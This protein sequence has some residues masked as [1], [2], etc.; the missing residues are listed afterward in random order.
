MF[1]LKDKEEKTIPGA[2]TTE[3]WR[4]AV[5]QEL[6]G[7]D[8]EFVLGRRRIVVRDGKEVTAEH[9]KPSQGSVPVD[10]AGFYTETG[11]LDLIAR[12][13][14]S[15]FDMLV[16]QLRS[17]MG[18]V[19]F[20]GAGF[21]APFGFPQW[22]KFITNAAEFHSSPEQVL[23]LVA[24]GDYIE[25]ASL[26]WKESP[27]RFQMRVANE[28]G[29]DV[30]PQ[31]TISAAVGLLPALGGGPVITTNFDHVLE[32]AFRAAGSPFDN[33]ITGPQ[34][35]SLIGAM[36][37]NEHVLIKMHGDASDRS[38][39]VFT[40]K[41]Y[42][43][44]YSK[45]SESGDARSHDRPATISQL[46][47]ILFTNR[48]LLFLGCSLDRDRTLDVLRDIKKDLPGLNH[49][50]ILA[51]AFGISQHRKRR[52]ELDA[53][54]VNPLWFYPGDFYRIIFLLRELIQ[55]ASTRMVWKPTRSSGSPPLPGA[56][57]PGAPRLETAPSFVTTEPPEV[58]DELVT[59]LKRVARRI[60]T[61]R[62]AFFLG[63]GV[64]LT[65]LM[66]ARGFYDSLASDY[67]LDQA[68]RAD[69][70]QYMVDLEGRADAWATARQRLNTTGLEPSVVFRF[71]VQLPKFFRHVE[72]LEFAQQWLF[73]T[74]YDTMLEDVFDANDEPFHL[75]YYQADG[76]D[77]GRFLHRS[78]DGV[79]RAIER[80]QNVRLLE[81]A[82]V[83]VKLDGGM[84]AYDHLS[85][86]VAISPMDFAMS[87]G[88]LP[89]ALPAV[90]LDILRSR[91]L[92]VLGSSL[93][94]VHVQRLVR[95][96]TEG[97]CT[98]KT[99]AIQNRVTQ[100][101]KRYWTAARVCLQACDLEDFI[102][103]LWW[104]ISGQLRQ[105]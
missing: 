19:P 88:R 34:P 75:L 68:Y 78:P 67:G 79:V 58:P 17:P 47:W 31:Q 38:A 25:A 23:D 35:D 98:T 29:M 94:A 97:T 90:V 72:K 28:F 10:I 9:E 71:L 1:A 15:T 24:K 51:G 73:T 105:A 12:E 21:S 54:G 46:A 64:H 65:E 84:A 11:L 82:H 87:A 85:E 69:I 50:A 101:A 59:T 53:Y 74:N 96:S 60:T 100:D 27:D 32:T 42:G 92:L 44:Q 56:D 83:I 102:P 8:V 99:W 57:L 36:H 103:A 45:G 52:L 13:N 55:E 4:Y 7:D 63:A 93:E 40:G 33:I 26:L 81:G 70:A 37:R 20:V 22:S 43:L 89:T 77:E 14:Q 80:P 104:H 18:V 2:P 39:R 3:E 66:A 49:Y 16:R 91:S 48:P 30:S 5:R 95:W 76:P 6:G 62:M 86:S 41:E 61:G